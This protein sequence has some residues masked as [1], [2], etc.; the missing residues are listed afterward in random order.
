MSFPTKNDLEKYIKRPISHPLLLIGVGDFEALRNRMTRGRWKGVT[1][2]L[3]EQ[4]DNLLSDPIPQLPR[5]LYD[6]YF[7]TGRRHLFEGPYHSRRRNVEKLT[8]AYIFTGKESY[9][10]R[11]RDYI[12][13]I[14][15]EFTWVIPAHSRPP[16]HP[17]DIRVVDLA[18]SGTAMLLATVWDLL[19]NH[20]D[21]ETLEWMRYNV[22]RHV[23][24]PLRDR[25]EEQWW[26][27]RYESN[28]CGVCCGNSGYALI[29][30]GLDENWSI[31]LLGKILKS[32][33][34][35]LS[36]ADPEG[37][38]VEGTGYW[39]Y[40]FSR[41]IYFADLLAKAT[42]NRIDLLKDSRI[43]ATI[44]FPV[45]TYLPPNSQVNFGD[46]GKAPSGSSYIDI[47]NLFLAYY[48]E[49]SIAW[50]IKRLEEEGLLNGGSISELLW[51]PP[52]DI[53]P[54]PPK[55]TSKWYR[56]IGWIITRASWDDLNA[57]ILAVKAGHNGEPHNHVDVG[58]FIYHCY[59]NSF[60]CDLGVG[61]YDREY[62]GPRR[63]ENPICGAEGHNLIFV[64]GKSQGIGPEYRGEITDFIREEDY[65]L[66]SLDITKAYPPEVLAKAVRKL[67]FFKYNGLLLVDEVVCREGAL[68]E[69]RLHFK[70]SLRQAQQSLIDISEGGGSIQIILDDP[71]IDAA[72]DSHKMLRTRDTD[73]I[74]APYIRLMKRA[75]KGYS[76]IK[77]YIVPYRSED[78]L[79]I[80]F[81][82][83]KEIQPKLEKLKII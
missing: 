1:Q 41:V 78:D 54:M 13:A 55:E 72:V 75:D 17:E 9:L 15:E 6:D 26:S 57:P 63:Y 25:F 64:D 23:L 22:F 28:W 19:H 70:G 18:S 62:F 5:S 65:D 81:N 35:F 47:L 10:D 59:G 46:T 80:H 27:R 38:W 3:L 82:K 48:R 61:I 4:A 49:P 2:K 83:I 42:G 20:L 39:F 43:K 60:I 69:S 30:M 67:V 31:D 66:I 40:G 34:G 52:A 68:V 24:I 36:T 12:W 51:E 76:K 7:R 32:I 8:L 37:A 77:A 79:K 71:S 16:F 29:L 53:E 50:Y 58:Q 45:W 21:K 73:L 44:T 56:R 11:C 33:D 14:M 74:N